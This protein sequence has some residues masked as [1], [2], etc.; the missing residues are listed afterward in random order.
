VGQ[1]ENRSSILIV[2][3]NEPMRLLLAHIVTQDLRAEVTLAGT[4]EDALRLANQDT[5]DVILLDLLMPGIGGFEVL[6]RIR[7]NSV[8]RSTPV[9]V[10]S[11][12]GTSVI[13]REE[14]VSIDRATTLGANAVVFKPFT[15]SQLILAVKEQLHAKV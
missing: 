4:C 6:R 14:S 15:N 9:I 3:D 5:Y 8:N 13:V 12:R 10:V 11:V 1:A 2:D 7:E